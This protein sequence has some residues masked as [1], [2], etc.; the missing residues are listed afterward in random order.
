VRATGVAGPSRRLFSL[1]RPRHRG[2]VYQPTGQDRRRALGCGADHSTAESRRR[3]L[4]LAPTR[5]SRSGVAYLGLGDIFAALVRWLTQ[6]IGGLERMR[7]VRLRPRNP[8]RSS[9]LVFLFDIT[10]NCIDVFSTQCDRVFNLFA[11]QK[12]SAQQPRLGRT[13]PR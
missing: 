7:I 4:G 11:H 13:Q 9:A 5:S 12:F 8:L 3:V 10:A 2:P 1:Y 6:L